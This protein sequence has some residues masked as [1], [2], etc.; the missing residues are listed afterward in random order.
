MNQKTYSFGKFHDS[1]KAQEAVGA[2][3][4]Q[5]IPASQIRVTAPSVETIPRSGPKRLA[6]IGLVGGSLFGLLVGGIVFVVPK[7]VWELAYDA[8]AAMMGVFLTTLVGVI[9]GFIFVLGRSTHRVRPTHIEHGVFVTVHKGQE[10]LIC[11]AKD[12]FERSDY[13]VNA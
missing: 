4:S 9:L 8:R 10:A 3:L 1:Q 12:E 6:L 7:V 5:G 2:L 13:F 11:R